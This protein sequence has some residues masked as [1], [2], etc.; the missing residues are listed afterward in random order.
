MFWA[1]NS[2]PNRAKEPMIISLYATSRGN[3]NIFGLG[4]RSVF[5]NIFSLAGGANLFC[6][7]QSSFSIGE[8][9]RVYDSPKKTPIPRRVHLFADCAMSYFT[10]LLKTS[11]R[12][13]TL[14]KLMF[15][16]ARQ[17]AF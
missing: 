4:L 3:S 7:H 2:R 9:G 10:V 17:N 12:E 1:L 11:L 5:N 8:V 13:D 16:V 6:S 14:L 15:D